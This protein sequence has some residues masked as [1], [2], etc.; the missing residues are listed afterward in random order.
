MLAFH[1]WGSC[2]STSGRLLESEL[3][4]A[5]DVADKVLDGIVHD[6]LDAFKLTDL[7]GRRHRALLSEAVNPSESV[8]RVSLDLAYRLH[9]HFTGLVTA[10]QLLKEQDQSFFVR[11]D[12]FDKDTSAGILRQEIQ[13][14]VG[15][16]LYHLPNY[17]L[18]VLVNAIK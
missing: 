17:I 8:L 10:K 18:F 7:I 15:L 9:R 3:T 12:L 14:R 1:R 5:L 13:I 4:I 11:A 2:D 16:L 6:L